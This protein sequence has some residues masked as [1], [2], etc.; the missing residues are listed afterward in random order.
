MKGSLASKTQA[1]NIGCIMFKRGVEGGAK[2]LRGFHR[3]REIIHEPVQSLQTNNDHHPPSKTLCD[4]PALS[5]NRGRNHRYSA[6]ISSRVGNIEQ[7]HVTKT[8]NES[9]LTF[10]SHQTSFIQ[11]LRL[12]TK[13]VVLWKQNPTKMGS[14][15]QSPSNKRVDKVQNQT[16]PQPHTTL[17][18][19]LD[20]CSSQISKRNENEIEREKLQLVGQCR[21]ADHCSRTGNHSRRG[22]RESLVE[23]EANHY[24]N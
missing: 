2:K 3:F 18:K 4:R 23:K 11:P 14:V 24:R 6:T 19:N 7:P 20:L 10:F 13:Y 12:V 5:C 8:P 17:R 16:R 15:R 1:R 21:F 22:C 9:I